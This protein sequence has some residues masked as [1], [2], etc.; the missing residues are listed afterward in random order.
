MGKQLKIW[1]GRWG[2][3]SHVY[4][5]A[6]SRADAGRLLCKA[7]GYQLRGIDREIK[8]YFSEGHWGRRMAGITPERGVWVDDQPYDSDVV[9][10]RVV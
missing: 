10:R 4:V 2:G 1:N 6:Y 5:A 8:E 3:G 9:P 7:A